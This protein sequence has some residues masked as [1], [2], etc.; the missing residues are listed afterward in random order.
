MPESD[1]PR[2]I[3]SVENALGVLD[4][5]EARETVGV[6]E[7]AE[8]LDRSKGTVHTHLATLAKHGY[9]VNDDGRYRL[10]LRYL[11]LAEAAK[12]HVGSYDAV[13]R[14]LDDLAATHGERAQFAVEE[15]GKAVYVYRATG[16]DAVNPSADIGRYEHLHSIGLGK[17]ILS[18]LPEA[19]VDA[20][21]AEHGLPERTA[22]TVTSR[23]ALA[24][25]LDRVR[26]RGYAVDDEERVH[27]IRCVAMPLVTGES[28][29]VGAMSV[30]GPASRMTDDRIQ[31]EILP[32]L[33][34]AVNVVEVNAELG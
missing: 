22:E 29:P 2:T 13:T 9:V 20:I 11:G 26:E 23:E 12:S 1:A 25:E 16:S 28:E 31:S 21:V 7:L 19:R 3:E 17:A 5:L 14:E 8:A 34:Q 6:S 30:S 10:S 18:V 27:G 24:E 15:G 33:R 32:D 4:E